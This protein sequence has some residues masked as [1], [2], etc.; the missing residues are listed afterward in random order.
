VIP[1]RLLLGLAALSLATT[2]TARADGMQS[3]ADAMAR[4]MDTFSDR[5]QWNAMPG[6]S[7]MNPSGWYSPWSDPTQG[8]S[9]SGSPWNPQNTPWQ[10]QQW[11]QWAPDTGFGYTQPP[12]LDGTW[13]ANSGA[14]M[15]IRQGFVRLYLSEDLSQDYELKLSGQDFL[16]RDTRTGNISSYTY[17]RLEDHMM[18][19]DA[20]G[21]VLLLQ[22]MPVTSW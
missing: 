11:G 8:W 12:Q 6:G 1:K 15:V 3:M 20:T 22:R 19:R 2:G 10:W 14:V 21:N 4:M 18:L 16:L 17:A 7:M 9:G 5:L 13:V